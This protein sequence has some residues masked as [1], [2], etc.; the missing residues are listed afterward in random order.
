MGGDFV[1]KRTEELIGARRREK[2]KQLHK[3]QKEEYDKIKTLQE[4]EGLAE[5]SNGV[6]KNESARALP[7]FQTTETRKPETIE[8][9]TANFDQSEGSK[10]EE[11]VKVSDP[12]LSPEVG[13]GIVTPEKM[14]SILRKPTN[15]FVDAVN[16]L[17]AS[18]IPPATSTFNA[19]Q[20]AKKLKTEEQFPLNSIWYLKYSVLSC[21][22]VRYSN[23]LMIHGE[24]LEN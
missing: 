21:P 6:G 14:P 9:E 20:F 5:S 7:T 13:R 12:G 22:A 4:T 15:K 23:R 10:V 8:I 3:E 16:S 1:S 18:L 2:S 11:K 19:E 24:F 17:V